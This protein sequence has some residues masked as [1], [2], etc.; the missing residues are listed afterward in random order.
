MW[1][2]AGGRGRGHKEKYVRLSKCNN[3][4]IP[5]DNNTSFESV[6]PEN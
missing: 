4:S 5:T 1:R 6:N 2:G 3:V